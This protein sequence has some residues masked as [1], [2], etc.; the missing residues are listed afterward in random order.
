MHVGDNNSL[1]PDVQQVATVRVVATDD[2]ASDYVYCSAEHGVTANMLCATGVSTSGKIV[3]T[4][5][6]DSGGAL[7]V[8]CAGGET[9]LAGV[10]SWGYGCAQAD[11]PGVYTRMSRCVRPCVHAWV[12]VSCLTLTHDVRTSTLTQRACM[13]VWYHASQWYYVH[14]YLRT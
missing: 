1:F 14:L 8:Q 10:V 4:C 2:D 9:V 7:F 11:S 5:V 6:G 13:Y 12:Q 3:D